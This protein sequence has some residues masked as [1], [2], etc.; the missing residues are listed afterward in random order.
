VSA[1]S[2]PRRRDDGF[3]AYAVSQ[4]EQGNW[5]GLE[6]QLIH[7]WSRPQG[8]RLSRDECRI[9]YEILTG[10]R[11]RPR[12]RPTDYETE[13]TAKLIAL[14]SLLLEAEGDPVEAAVAATMQ[15][16]GVSR[17]SVFAARKE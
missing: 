4:A 2:T 6:A 15:M 14:Y 16:Y 9:L 17:A 10:T 12:K 11:R 7:G 3:S 1:G 8:I 5:Q 13:N